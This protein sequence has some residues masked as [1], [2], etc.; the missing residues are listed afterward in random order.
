MDRKK[1]SESEWL[2]RKRRIDPKL[3]AANSVALVSTPQESA[4][5]EVV[6]SATMVSS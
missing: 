6:V 4:T 2:T 5:G 3:D 1:H